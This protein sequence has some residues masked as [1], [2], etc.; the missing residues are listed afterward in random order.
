MNSAL[1]SGWPAV[2]TLLN[3]QGF[4]FDEFKQE[5]ANLARE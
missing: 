4:A 1:V 2:S 3:R 5:A